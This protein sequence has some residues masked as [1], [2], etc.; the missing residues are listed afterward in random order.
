[1]YLGAHVEEE[2]GTVYIF[3][4]WI[5]GGSVAQL[6]KRFGPFQVG[7]VRTYTRQILF[8]LEY[9]HANGIVHRDIKGLLIIA[10]CYLLIYVL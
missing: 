6:L 3:Q 8:G 4:E 10:K 1:M 9:L 2:S 7:V 5:P